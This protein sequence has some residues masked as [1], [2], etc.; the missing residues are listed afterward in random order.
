MTSLL[1]AACSSL[2]LFPF[3]QNKPGNAL[4]EISFGGIT[5]AGRWFA[6]MAQ[7]QTLLEQQGHVAAERSM[8]LLYPDAPPF[9]PFGA[10][11]K[12]P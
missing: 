12:V 2:R 7:V 6:E 3:H 11:S 10:F 5:S 1:T 9:H 8:P 4:M